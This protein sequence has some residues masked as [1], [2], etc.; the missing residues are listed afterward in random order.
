MKSVSRKISVAAIA[1]ASFFITTPSYGQLEGDFLKAGLSD[2]MTL[3]EAYI[4]PFAN[5]FGA[6]FNSAW[7]N[8][9]K[10]HNL[11]GFDLTLSVSAGMV[12][13]VDKTGI[14]ICLFIIRFMSISL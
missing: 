11:G 8:T 7:Y 9:A 4:T 1:V 13:D 6:A 5:G 12:P 3:M 10:P 2:G 14:S